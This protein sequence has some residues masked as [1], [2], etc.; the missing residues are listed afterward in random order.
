MG[1]GNRHGVSTCSGMKK[2]IAL[3]LLAFSVGC[4]SGG[5]SS[6]P[7]A[8]VAAATRPA[9]VAPSRPD[10]PLDQV[11]A[12][13]TAA[14][15][16]ELDLDTATEARIRDLTARAFLDLTAEVD[17]LRSDAEKDSSSEALGDLV[18]QRSSELHARIEK[19]LP[20]DKV[21]P[22]RSLVAR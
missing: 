11:L 5:R 21:E 16:S 9:E 6:A 7:V 15:A 10:A 3:S 8:P 1:A 17:A 18:E 2:L 22:Y 12:A 13:E 20:A 14:L 4:G 19:E